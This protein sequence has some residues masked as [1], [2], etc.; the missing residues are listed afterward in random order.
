MGQ[1]R[2]VGVVIDRGS[3]LGSDALEAC[4]K[5]LQSIDHEYVVTINGEFEIGE[6]FTDRF[7]NSF[8]SNAYKAFNVILIILDHI[9]VQR[10]NIHSGNCERGNAASDH[11]F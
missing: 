3:S 4:V 5:A 8:V 7:A 11:G 2:G 9:L 6:G 1:S 10:K